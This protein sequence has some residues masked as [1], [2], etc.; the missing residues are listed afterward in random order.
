[1]SR[2]T[3][4]RPGTPSLIIETGTRAIFHTILLF[5]LYLLFAG[6]NRPGGGFVGGLTAGAACVLVYAALGARGLGVA[7]PV[8]PETLLGAGILLAGGTGVAALLT[9]A[10]F[11]T[12]AAAEIPVPVIGE[13]H[14]TSVLVFDIGVYAVVVGLVLSLLST[15]GA[16][17]SA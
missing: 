6:H 1:V 10:E 12:S 14:V 2:S 17:P 13:I 3:S 16:E 8:R 4:H 11:L 15:L 9:G 7:V 5:S